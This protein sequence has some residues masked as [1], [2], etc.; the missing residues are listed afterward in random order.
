MKRHGFLI[1]AALILIALSAA[2]YL[3]HYA[4]FRDA[5][6]IFKFMVHHLAFLPLDVLVVALIIDRI[7]S[8][9]EKQSM[10]NKMNMVAG[11]FFDEM[12]TRLM[13]RLMTA[14]DR[15]EVTA[16]LGVKRDWGTGD[17]RKAAVLTDTSKLRANIHAISLQE[18]KEFLRQERE[19][20]LRLLENPN[21]LE[22]ERF[23]DMLWA[24]S[25]MAEELEMRHDLRDLPESDLAHI[26]DDA[27]RAF[28]AL[29]AE[30]LDYVR[31]LKLHYP[32]LFSLVLRTHPFQE[33]RSP[34]VT[35]AGVA[36]A[37]A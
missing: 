26:A 11:V 17:F 31:H 4:I 25:H 21:L 16:R 30:W 13:E 18:L 12:G 14:F 10:L 33:H 9:R 27:G 5:N 35:A 28:N 32:Y 3:I 8:R 34:I 20:M 22:H 7:L 2:I 29:A 6:H 15:S 1:A 36:Q 23:T 24:V 37:T 19:F